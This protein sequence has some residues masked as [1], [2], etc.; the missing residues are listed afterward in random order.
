MKDLL[1]NLKLVLAYDGTRYA[2]FQRQ[3]NGVTIQ[4]ELETA[5]SKITGSQVKL[6]GAGRTDAGVHA[7]GQVANFY[8]ETTIPVEKLLKA[9]NAVLPDDIIVK[10]VTEAAPAFH[11]R[12]SALSKTY[13]Y[14]IYNSEFRPVFERNFVYHYK[15]PLDV[16]KIEET[17]LLIVG[18]HDFKS[19]QAAGSPVKTTIRTVNFCRVHRDGPEIIFTINADGFLYHMVR[20]IIGT[21]ILV[22][23]GRLTKNQFRRILEQHD[24]GLAGP[25]APAGGLCLEEVFY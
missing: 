16:G 18:K 14:R 15:Y 17:C 8:S 23:N 22:G 24:R 6:I 10:S 20:N 4:E 21:L 3:S 7:R 2:G 11:A 12:F 19:F 25:T 13:S 1:K 9:L 5:I